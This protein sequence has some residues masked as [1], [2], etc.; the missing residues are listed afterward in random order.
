MIK[1]LLF[2]LV[3]V[4]SVVI[5]SR[6]QLPVEG[7]W[8]SRLGIKD[9]KKAE[10]LFIEYFATDT[11]H[12]KG[13]IY[14]RRSY[15]LF[16]KLRNLAPYCDYSFYNYAIL[17]DQEEK[18]LF[19]GLMKEEKDPAV[20][21]MYL[22]DLIELADA[23]IT[24]RDSI[25]VLRANLHLQGGAAMAPLTEG[26]ASL[27]RAH[28]IYEYCKK[29]MPAELYKQEEVYNNY[30]KAFELYT[31]EGDKNEED[32]EGVYLG[33]YFDS[34]YD[35]Y[36]TDTVKYYQQFLEDYLHV[37]TVCDHVLLPA[38]NAPDEATKL[39]I[40]K[41]AP[42]SGY[43]YFSF[44]IKNEFKESGAGSA[45]R[46]NSYFGSVLNNHRKDRDFLDNAIH[47]MYENSAFTTDAFYEYCEVAYEIE[48]TYE[49]AL[50][51][52]LSCKRDGLTND[53]VTY[54]KE[55]KTLG[56][57][58]GQRA[59]CSYLIGL[60]LISS[61]PTYMKQM[62]DGTEK[63]TPCETGSPEYQKWFDEMNIA[64]ANLK[65]VF[66]YSESLMKSERLSD[67]T[68]CCRASHELGRCYMRRM[69]RDNIEDCDLAIAYFEQAERLGTKD[70]SY[71]ETDNI[72]RIEDSRS[73]YKSYLAEVAKN[74]K[75]RELYEK[76]QR[77]YQAYLRK[78]A[79][80]EKFWHSR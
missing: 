15:E 36:K 40:L 7:D 9:Q 8:R 33:E 46:L 62:K 50:G 63:E 75:Q 11:L 49:N 64:I 65:D 59:M 25:N 34:C 1:R 12:F 37:V 70:V 74:K 47:L 5:D 44:Q 73:R 18:F 43:D 35:L 39:Q 3:L 53:M 52:A 2:L 71:D 29:Y 28:L 21:L 80:E 17:N 77:E 41:R 27:W 61:R 32:V 4:L 57:S 72:T 24:E 22:Q 78:K 10:S 31:K 60:N 20:R 14:N 30:K 66:N 76:Q 55:A 19:N 54:L 6:A 51:F 26:V 48:P 68:L 58:D 69:S 79:E 67:R 13:G 56:K 45:E 38:Y 16:R 23:L 42:F